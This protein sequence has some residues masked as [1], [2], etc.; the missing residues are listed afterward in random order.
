VTY[1]TFAEAVAAIAEAA[2]CAP[3]QAKGELVADLGKGRRIAEGIPVRVPAWAL[4]SRIVTRRKSLAHERIPDGFWIDDGSSNDPDPNSEP[5]QLEV[6]PGGSTAFQGLDGYIDIR[7]LQQEPAPG[8]TKAM[9]GDCLTIAV[10][11]AI[12][13]FGG[14]F[15]WKPFCDHVRA[16]LEVTQQDRGFGDRTIKRRATLL[17]GHRQQEDK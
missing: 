16:K 3:E 12:E 4:Y 6:Y 14:R 5:V 10:K 13:H 8:V 9:S 2:G 11:E 15:E 7:I 1:L 17:I